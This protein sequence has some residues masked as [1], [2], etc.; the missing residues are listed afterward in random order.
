MEIVLAALL[1]G[2]MHP[3]F[4]ENRSRG[5]IAKLCMEHGGK[6]ANKWDRRWG[7]NYGCLICVMPDAAQPPTWNEYCDIDDLKHTLGDDF[8]ISNRGEF[9]Q[10]SKLHSE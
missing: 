5:E 7:G 8:D 1:T 2:C 3:H 4:D 9:P 10:E 6:L